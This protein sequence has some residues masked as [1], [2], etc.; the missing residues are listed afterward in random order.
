MTS[1]NARIRQ[2]GITATVKHG[3]EWKRDD[4]GWEHNAY[5]ITLRRRGGQSITVPWMQG[6]AHQTGPTPADVLDAIV[7]DAVSYENASDWRD[8]AAEFGYGTEDPAD[9]RRVR[10]TWAKLEALTPRVRRF[11]GDDFDAVA[12]DTDRL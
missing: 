11:L 6:M 4:Q 7:G 5:R 3:P 9:V 8:F 1:M 10:K 12:F 2:L